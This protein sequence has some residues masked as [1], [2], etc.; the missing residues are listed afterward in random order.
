MAADERKHIRYN[1]KQNDADRR[2][3]GDSE[4]WWVCAGVRAGLRIWWSQC[5]GRRARRPRRCRRCRAPARAGASAA[6]PPSAPTA[7]PPGPPASTWTRAPRAA[8]TTTR[9]GPAR[10]ARPA[11]APPCATDSVAIECGVDVLYD[12]YCCLYSEFGR[13]SRESR[14]P[15]AE[16]RPSRTRPWRRNDV[17]YSGAGYV[18]AM[19][20]QLVQKTKELRCWRSTAKRTRGLDDCLAFWRRKSDITK[21]DGRSAVGD[22]GRSGGKTTGDVSTARRSEA[23]CRDEYGWRRC[24][25]GAK[26][27]NTN[28][29]RLFAFVGRGREL[30][31]ER[32]G[33]MHNRRENRTYE[34][35]PARRH[36]TRS[37]KRI[38]EL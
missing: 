10:P 31:P 1:K 25:K 2:S 36:S 9:A 24:Q 4:T 19:L 15:H 37:P 23:E 8:A 13:P 28:K 14:L 34:M 7:A 5:G 17:S 21:R 29:L 20:A 22:R 32:R 6:R 38:H 27:T 30:Q 11:V 33:W 12:P 16:D 3:V 35:L 18:S 26:R